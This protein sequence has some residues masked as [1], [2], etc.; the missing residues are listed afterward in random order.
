MRRQLHV[1]VSVSKSV[2]QNRFFRF[3]HAIHSFADRL[4]MHLTTTEEA[5]EIEHDC[6]DSAI[7]GGSFEPA[8]NIVHS[9][10]ADWG[11]A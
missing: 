11:L 8:D 9:V 7:G 6:L 10:F 1:V 4:H 5:I 3:P 2:S